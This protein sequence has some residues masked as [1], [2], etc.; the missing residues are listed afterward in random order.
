MLH[1][2]C[3]TMAAV[4]TP[5]PYAIERS[6][7]LNDA[8]IMMDEH[9]LHH[10]VV[11]ENDDISAILSE[12]ELQHHTAAYGINTNNDLLVGDVGSKGIIAA[13][14][15]DPLD[16]VLHAMVEKHLS[17][18]IVLREGELA[19]I[20]TTTDACKHFALFL[21]QQYPNDDIPDIIA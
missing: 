3:P 8:A 14:I 17:A 18:V 9:R 21:Q 5:F 2:K 4:F 12:T 20:F 1:K 13:D 19:G 6:A 10:L 15:N 11:L 16:R 7:P